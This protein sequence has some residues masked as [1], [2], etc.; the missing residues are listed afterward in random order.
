MEL[1]QHPALEASLRGQET[2]WAA[3]AR[4]L[5]SGR[6]PAACR[7]ALASAQRRA[8]HVAR[9]VLATVLGDLTQDLEAYFGIRLRIH[10]VPQPAPERAP[11]LVADLLPPASR[12]G[13]RLAWSASGEEE[14]WNVVLY[15]PLHPSLDRG[16]RLLAALLLLCSWALRRSVDRRGYV[17]RPAGDTWRLGAR[18]WAS[19]AASLSF[20]ARQ[21]QSPEAERSAVLVGAS[22]GYG[23]ETRELWRAL[24]Q[25]RGYYELYLPG[26]LAEMVGDRMDGPRWEETGPGW[27]EWLSRCE[28]LPPAW[29]ERVRQLVCTPGGDVQHLR[30]SGPYGREA[31][32]PS[33]AERG[34]AAVMGRVRRLRSNE[35][36]I[37]AAA[38]VRRDPGAFSRELSRAA[39]TPVVVEVSDAW[40]GRPWGARLYPPPGEK[41]PWTIVLDSRMLSK[42]T[43]EEVVA[44]C[45]HEVGHAAHNVGAVGRLWAA[46]DRGE[47]AR[48][49]VHAQDTLETW[50]RPQS[51][52]EMA[53]NYAV[54]AGYGPELASALAALRRAGGGGDLTQVENEGRWAASL[55]QADARR[56]VEMIEE[57]I[58]TSSGSAA[59]ALRRMQGLPAQYP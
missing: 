30:E 23:P 33:L 27:H 26:R 53:D 8:E 18:E 6:P 17:A 25:D 34:R 16:D 2:E 5:P 43:P 52:E 57:R 36:L 21:K 14:D 12:L 42:W 31:G 9:G 38:N 24:P 54:A 56:Q 59:E 19:G 1:S 32:A 11:A 37:E 3:V 40:G 13:S 58:R 44:V 4:A 47:W 15:W 45:L 48:F 28:Q 20:L 29:A 46:R 41:H 7:L 10:A 35:K 55:Q 39:L 22:H 49:W 50:L 51:R